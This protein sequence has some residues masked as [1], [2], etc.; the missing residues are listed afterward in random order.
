MGAEVEVE[1]EVEVEAEAEAAKSH[2][3]V[4]LGSWRSH[5]RWD[6]S[7]RWWDLLPTLNFCYIIVP[8]L[9]Q[10]CPTMMISVYFIVL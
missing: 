4:G 1:V 7:H 5:Q 9:L 8:L 10:S 6:R 2:Q 3:A